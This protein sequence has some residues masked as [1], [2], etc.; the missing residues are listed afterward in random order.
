[1]ALPVGLVA[2][3]E[4]HKRVSTWFDRTGFGYA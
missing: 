4:W 3:V 2:F 1:M